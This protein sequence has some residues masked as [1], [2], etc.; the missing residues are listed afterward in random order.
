MDSQFGK[1]QPK[2]LT[3]LQIIHKYETF[4]GKAYQSF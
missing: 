4:L 3:N 2:L 1:Y